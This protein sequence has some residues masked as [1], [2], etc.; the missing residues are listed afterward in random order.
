MDR[1]Y[2]SGAVES[3]PEPVATSGSF[4]T[5]GS[6]ITGQSATVPG[7]YW[8]YSVTEEIRNAIIAVG[9]TPDP[10][11]VNQLA[12]AM[13]KFLPL[14]G[15]KM[16]GNI[17]LAPN[18]TEAPTLF[19]HLS[20]VDPYIQ[21]YNGKRTDF[22]GRILIR[23]QNDSGEKNSLIINPDGSATV[24]GVQICTFNN[25]YGNAVK[26]AAITASGTTPIPSGGTWNLYYWH[27]NGSELHADSVTL[28]GGSTW[29]NT[30]GKALVAIAFRLA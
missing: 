15:G 27:I 6:K 8:F 13:G 12:E 10:A 2:Q 20:S 19:G 18:S 14:T 28:A 9:T 11:K 5:S 3:P 26:F 17:A 22:P 25:M 30:T 21:F 7:A 23:S 4:P 16:R 1:V 29:T 24:G